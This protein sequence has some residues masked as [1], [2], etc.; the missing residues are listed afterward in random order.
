MMRG[1][2][3]ERLR[4]SLQGDLHPYLA[5]T[6][7]VRRWLRCGGPNWSERRVTLPLAPAPEAGASLLGYAL[8]KTNGHQ[9]IAPR[10]PVWRTGMYLSTPMPGSW[11]ANRSSQ[12]V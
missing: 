6:D 8:G 5:A 3:L 1:G 10:T 12:R 2:S 7:G 4:W 11:L 9:G